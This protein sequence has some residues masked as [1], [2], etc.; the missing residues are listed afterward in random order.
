MASGQCN[1]K[2]QTHTQSGKF[3]PEVR[4]DAMHLFTTLILLERPKSLGLSI[5]MWEMPIR[6]SIIIIHGILQHK[7]TRNEFI[8]H[9]GRVIELVYVLR[10]PA[11]ADLRNG[12]LEQHTFS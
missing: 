8:M 3:K 9:F 7:C 4:R 2:V 12:N 1:F 10:S 6:T 11:R 5:G